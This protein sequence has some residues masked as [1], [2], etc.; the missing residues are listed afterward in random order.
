M[1]KGRILIG[2]TFLLSTF[3]KLGAPKQRYGEYFTYPNFF[4]FIFK[5]K[6]GARSLRTPSRFDPRPYHFRTYHTK[7]NIMF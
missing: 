7:I 5:K 1:N 2:T 6:L 4:V 3:K